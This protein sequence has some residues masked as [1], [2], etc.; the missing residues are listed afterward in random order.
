MKNTVVHLP[1]AIG[2]SVWTV[3]KQGYVFRNKVVRYIINGDNPHD[4]RMVMSFQ[5]ANGDVMTRYSAVNQFG[6]TV[7]AS[8]PEAIRAAREMLGV[9]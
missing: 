9:V 7:F 2:K 8:E 4:N 1:V 6:R 3:T 5:N